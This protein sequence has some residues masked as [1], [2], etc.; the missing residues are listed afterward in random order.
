MLWKIDDPEKRH[1]CGDEVSVAGPVDEHLLRNRGRRWDSEHREVGRN[2][3][4][5]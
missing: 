4:N 1:P 5:F 3:D 2:G